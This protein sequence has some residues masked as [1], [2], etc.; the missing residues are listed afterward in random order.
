MHI[1]NHYPDKSEKLWEKIG[2]GI[3]L[4]VAIVGVFLIGY[5]L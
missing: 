5:L 4:V 3:G 1:I 2:A